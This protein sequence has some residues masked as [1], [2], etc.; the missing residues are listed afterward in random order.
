MTVDLRVEP[1]GTTPRRLLHLLQGFT[2]RGQTH[3]NLLLSFSEDTLERYISLCWFLCY[4]SAVLVVRLGLGTKYPVLTLKYS[5]RSAA[6]RFRVW[7]IAWY[8]FCF[9]A[10]MLSKLQQWAT[11]V[12]WV[13]CSFTTVVYIHHPAATHLL[14]LNSESASFRG[15]FE[16]QL[17]CSTAQR[18]SQSEGSYKCVPPSPCFWRMHHRY[19]PSWPH[20]S[21]DS[22]HTR[23][24]R[25]KEGK[26]RC[27]VA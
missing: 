25:K 21:Q 18:L 1:W 4:D 24:R 16:G 23:K 8:I 6:Q 14:C 7:C 10:K 27:R 11:P 2:Q 19:D 5:S 26:W 3:Q 22:L 17:H 20:I 13:T 9:C 15:A 12:H